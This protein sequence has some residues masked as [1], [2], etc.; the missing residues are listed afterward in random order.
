MNIAACT[1]ESN[2]FE[3]NLFHITAECSSC[4]AK[5]IEAKNHPPTEQTVDADLKYLRQ[6]EIASNDIS[7][8]CKEAVEHQDSWPTLK[9][10]LESEIEKQEDFFK[11]LT[12][13]WP[14][15]PKKT[16]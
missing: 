8:I 10:R 13:V 16:G 3:G 6:V 5:P 14:Q 4:A 7:R 15:Y 2:L 9:F 11:M 1:I 12:P